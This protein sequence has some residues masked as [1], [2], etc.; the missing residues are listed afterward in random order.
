MELR[1]HPARVLE[2][3]VARGW[4]QTELARR[5]RVTD[6]SVSRLLNNGSVSVK[7][8]ARIARAL[9]QPVSRY[10][11]VVESEAEPKSDETPCVAG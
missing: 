9:G 10:V 1:K 2:D 5:A 3:M 6:D 7:Q 8:I 11:T 4:N